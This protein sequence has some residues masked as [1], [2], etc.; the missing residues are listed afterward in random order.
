MH[1]IYYDFNSLLRCRFDSN[2]SS[3]ILHS[4]FWVAFT[5]IDTKPTVLSWDLFGRYIPDSTYKKTHAD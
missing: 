1:L 5:E 3:G 2:L 4:E